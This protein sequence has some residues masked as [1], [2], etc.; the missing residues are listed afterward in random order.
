MKNKRL[1]ENDKTNFKCVW[2]VFAESEFEQVFARCISLIHLFLLSVSDCDYSKFL[3][4]S[5]GHQEKRA[6]EP[7]W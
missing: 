3:W 5:P 4:I 1:I 7:E 6:S 2:Y